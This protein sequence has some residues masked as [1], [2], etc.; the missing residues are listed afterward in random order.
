MREERK[1]KKKIM[2][3]RMQEEKYENKMIHESPDN[4]VKQLEL[5]HLDPSRRT[6]NL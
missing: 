6:K 1:K 2:R 5:V 4:L 3:R